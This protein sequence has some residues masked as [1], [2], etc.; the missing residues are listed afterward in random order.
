MP[1][2]CECWPL[3]LC[4]GGCR[5]SGFLPLHVAAQKGHLDVVM[6]LAAKWPETLHERSHSQWTAVHCAAREGHLK[7]MEFLLQQVPQHITS[8]TEQRQTALHL[9]AARGHF[10]VVDCLLPLFPAKYLEQR[11]EEGYTALQ[12]A[13]GRV[14][15]LLQEWR[16]TAIIFQVV[17]A[18][19]AQAKDWLWRLG[20][21]RRAKIELKAL[22][23]AGQEKA[24]VRV[25]PQRWNAWSLMSKISQLVEVPDHRLVLLFPNGEYLSMKTESKMQKAKLA[26]KLEAVKTSVS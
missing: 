6:F 13:R 9:A 1:G 16:Q 11:D 26:E 14:A 10:S 12:K 18:R 21:P 17:V 2:R 3:L 19:V 8:L 25:R 7:V 24:Q 15:D 5:A 23:V 4:D 20:C 22:T